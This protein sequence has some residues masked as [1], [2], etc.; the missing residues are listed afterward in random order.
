MTNVFIS[1]SGQQSKEIAEELRNWIPSVLQFAKPYYTPNDIEKGAK[2]GS[3]ISKKLSES[4]IGIV[5]LTKENFTK[6]WILF[7]AGAL[8]KDLEQ[9]KVC[10]ILFGMENTDLTG[11]LTTFQTTNFNKS[12]FKKMMQTVN[13]SGGENALPKETFDRVFDMWWP[14]LNEKIS[15]IIAEEKENSPEDLRSDRDLLEEI[16]ILTR[17]RQRSKT[18]ETEINSVPVALVRDFISTIENM[19]EHNKKFTSSKVNGEVAKQLRIADYLH[20]RSDGFDSEISRKLE[21]LEDDCGNFI[22][23]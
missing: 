20:N 23:F 11:P 21:K 2:W 14:Q 22:P 8:S 4:N 16:L 7:E 9:S 1:W 6:P 5:C 13:Q 17:A 19:M 18:I 3:E 10:S 15:S 12:D